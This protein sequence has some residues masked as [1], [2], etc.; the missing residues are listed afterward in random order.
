[1][2]PTSPA[3]PAPAMSSHDAQSTLVRRRLHPE[4]VFRLKI[5]AFA[6]FG[7]LILLDS[8]FLIVCYVTVDFFGWLNNP[9]FGWVRDCGWVAWALYF[10]AFVGALFS[11]DG[12]RQTKRP[13]GPV[14]LCLSM[15]IAAGC[16]L[17]F[18]NGR[19]P[20]FG[21]TLLYGPEVRAPL[22]NILTY[23]GAIACLV[24]LL[25]IAFLHIVSAWKS[26]GGTEV[27]GN[28]RL[29]PFLLTGTSVFLLY[30]GTSQ[31]K[32][33]AVGQPISIRAL[34]LSLAAHLAVSALIFLALAWSRT[35]ARWFPDPEFSRF[36]LR[37]AAGWLLGAVV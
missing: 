29:S 10:P 14:A 5:A 20:E 3:G 25:W 21:L 23:V 13:Q 33:S 12:N 31:A 30:A 17:Y 11:I 36:A 15:Q 24:P 26:A 35:I 27:A 22:G 32:L 28:L 37:A 9:F 16:A 19:K 7:A 1:M 34:V 2:S 18:S 8:I 6:C 4:T